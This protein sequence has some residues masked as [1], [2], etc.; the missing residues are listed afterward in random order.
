MDSMIFSS[1]PLLLVETSPCQQGSLIQ[2]YIIVVVY[3]H[4]EVLA[5][6]LHIHISSRQIQTT[7][8]DYR[9]LVADLQMVG[10]RQQVGH[11]HLIVEDIRYPTTHT[12]Q[13]I[14]PLVLHLQQVHNT[15]TWCTV[16]VHAVEYYAQ[17]RQIPPVCRSAKGRGSTVYAYHYMQSVEMQSE[18]Q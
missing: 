16:P 2:Y 7:C 17:C 13:Q 10:S 11:T 5:M 9:W 4:R 18:T 15:S 12:T 1:V 14:P 8:L 3:L 6:L